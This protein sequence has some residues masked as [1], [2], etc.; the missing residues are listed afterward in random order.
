MKSTYHFIFSMKRTMENQAYYVKHYAFQSAALLDLKTTKSYSLYAAKFK[1]ISE[2]DV[3]LN[4]SLQ[5]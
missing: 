2:G 4:F 1:N 3:Y 5:F